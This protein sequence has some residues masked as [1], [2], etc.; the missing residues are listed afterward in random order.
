MDEF[1]DPDD[2]E[3]HCSIDGQTVQHGTTRHDLYCVP[4]LVAG[5]SRITP[6]LPGDSIFCV[7]PTGVGQSRT[8]PRFLR[9]G[10]RLVSRSPASRNSGRRSSTARPV[11]TKEGH[12]GRPPRLPP[13]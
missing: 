8:P 11:G 6:L 2:I 5:L 7:T 9:A 10:E 4:E 13:S 12:R 1:A 3:L